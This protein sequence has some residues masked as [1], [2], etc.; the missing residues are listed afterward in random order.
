MLVAERGASANTIEAYRRDLI[1]FAN[2]IHGKKAELLGLS[3]AEIEDYLTHLHHKQL[4]ATSIVRKLSAIKQFYLYLLSEGLIVTLPTEW[5]AKPKTTRRLPKAITI[6]EMATILELCRQKHGFLPDQEH[7][8]LALMVELLYA[9]GMRI[10]ELISLQSNAIEADGGGNIALRITG[11]GS[12]ERLV[13][14]YPKAA[15]AFKLYCSLL[16]AQ[17]K[18]LF[19]SDGASGHITRQRVGQLL[20]ELAINA[21]IDPERLSPHVFRHSFAT[22]L[23]A[24]GADLRV[25]QELLGHRNI[26]TTQIYTKIDSARLQEVV[27]NFH[28]L[29]KR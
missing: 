17:A 5:V 18:W 11:K 4:A 23:L 25:I 19:P 12:K 8:R 16:P 20:K 28:P 14:L 29:A 1:D 6:A 10:S 7:Q 3:K 21:N 2:F 26:S 9:S 22:H 15:Q 13:M 24:K 27:A